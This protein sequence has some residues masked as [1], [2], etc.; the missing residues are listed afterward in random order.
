MKASARKDAAKLLFFPAVNV[1]RPAKQPREAYYVVL[2]HRSKRLQKIGA[3]FEGTPWFLAA[4]GAEER[5]ARD[6]SSMRAYFIEGDAE[7]VITHGC[8]PHKGKT[9]SFS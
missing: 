9:E 5:F 1:I 4:D 3:K 7:V 2:R 6:G 8:G